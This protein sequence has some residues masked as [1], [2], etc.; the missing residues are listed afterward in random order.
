VSD[1]ERSPT[2]GETPI[3]LNFPDDL[4]AEYPLEFDAAW[5]ATHAILE[6]LPG[7]NFANLAK[8]SPG[9]NRFDWAQY[10][11][12]SAI[13]M[14]RAG[15][16]LRRSGLNGGRLFDFGSYFGNVALFAR[17]LGFQVDA[18]DSYG[19]YGEAFGRVVPLLHEAGVR[20]VDLDSAEGRLSEIPDN[21]Y[22]AVLCLGVIEHIPHTPRP[23][24][25]ALNRV[26]RS[27]GVLVLETP[28]L[29]YIYTRERLNAGQSIFLPIEL[30]FHVD[31]PFEGHHREYTPREVAW[32]LEAIGHKVAELEMFNYS[33]YGLSELSGR[34]ADHWHR[35]EA[36]PE[37]RELILA[38]S[39]KPL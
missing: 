32:M 4:R 39:V 35:M 13:R 18:A 10:I 25:V 26:L 31:P 33:L 12:L 38:R 24:L 14:V 20:V 9:L 17:K 16:A 36:D 29:L 19:T 28:N 2:I 15:A 11:R 6:T 8:H 22:D 34:D 7:T 5:A 27:G 21:S 30:Q 23:L 3:R 1:L 37:F